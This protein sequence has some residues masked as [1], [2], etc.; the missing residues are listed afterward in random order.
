MLTRFPTPLLI[1]Q[2]ETERVL[3]TFVVKNGIK[4]ERGVK[5]EGIE[6][7]SDYVKVKIIN[8]GGVADEIFC[9]YIVGCD[10]AHS[11]VRKSTNLSFVGD[12]YPQDFILADLRLTWALKDNISLFMGSYGFMA[13][14]PMKDDV[15]R[16]LCSRVHERDSNTEPTIPDF[17]ESIRRLLPPEANVIFA[18]EKPFWM[19]RFRL[20]HRIVDNYREGRCFLA[21]DAAHIHSPAGGQGM[22]TGMQDSVNLAW[23]LATVIKGEQEESLLDSYN[24]ERHRIG[25]HLLD[26]TDRGFELM[27]TSN[28]VYLWLRNT[29][30]PWVLA[31]M[32]LSEASKRNRFRFVSELGVRYR[33][34]SIVSQGSTWKNKAIRGG[35]RMPDGKLM[36]VDGEVWLQSLLK[37]PKSHLVGF[38]GV[39]DRMTTEDVLSHIL[40]EIA[41]QRQGMMCHIILDSRPASKTTFN[42]ELGVMHNM[43]GMSGGG[44]VLVRPDGYIEWIG[45]LSDVHELEAFI[46]Q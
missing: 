12:A 42:D 33:H 28:P 23:K 30:A 3:E 15:W 35:N 44:I 19:S 8:E 25:K 40:Q 39:R 16:V 9:Q 31:L 2:A 24:V 29:L 5:A 43:L 34:S 37:A 13:L 11:I 10:G 22:N 20:H 27:A 17:E 26:V 6:Q 36:A 1:S 18:K 14:F 46:K 7:E 41:D 32:D 45:S 21:G 4:V 38:S